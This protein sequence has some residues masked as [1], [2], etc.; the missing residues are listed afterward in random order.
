MPCSKL[1]VVHTKQAVLFDRAMPFTALLAVGLP[2][3]T[4]ACK[5]QKTGH[6]FLFDDFHHRKG[7]GLVNARQLVDFFA[8]DF[9]EV[10]DVFGPDGQQIIE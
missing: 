4:H 6:R 2:G 1:V 10:R 7:V 3:R 8:K 9:A 5:P